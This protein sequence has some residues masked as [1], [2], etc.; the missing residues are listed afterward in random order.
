[1]RES[2]VFKLT[3]LDALHRVPRICGLNVVFWDEAEDAPRSTANSLGF[4]FKISVCAFESGMLIGQ[5]LFM[6]FGIFCGGIPSIDR[7]GLA[8]RQRSHER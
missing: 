1:M 5:L 6:G 4:L 3:S 8:P 2:S 7:S